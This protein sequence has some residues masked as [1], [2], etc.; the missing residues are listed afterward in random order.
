[1][2]ATIAMCVGVKQT[3]MF[4][5]KQSLLVC[6]GSLGERTTITTASALVPGVVHNGSQHSVTYNS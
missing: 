3:L 2:V 6:L 4:E 1:M 5:S